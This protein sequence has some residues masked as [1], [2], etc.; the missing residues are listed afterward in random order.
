MSNPSNNGSPPAQMSQLSVAFVD[1]KVSKRAAAKGTLMPQAQDVD[2]RE[3]N[4]SFRSALRTGERIKIYIGDTAVAE[5]TKPLL[6]ATSA[7]LDAMYHNGKITLPA[8]TNKD[9]VD[10]LMGYLA[11]VVN[12]PKR[13]VVMS[14]KLP[15]SEALS[16]CAAAHLLGM[17]KYTDNVY[18]M[19]EAILRSELP[20][21]QDLEDIA[22]F[23]EQHARLFKIVV[24]NLAMRVR[25]GTVP[26]PDDF[27]IY[28]QSNNTLAEAI[29]TANYKHAS[30][31]ARD[32]RRRVQHA[33]DEK[34]KEA[35]KHRAAQWKEKT[36]KRAALENAC[37][38][39]S[40]GG[41]NERKKFTAEERAHWVS[42]RRTQPPK[43][44]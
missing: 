33:N 5:L 39:K 29:K 42:T 41:V 43:G 10:H 9:G 18:K 2:I 28:L 44:C 15:L 20:T 4:S 25:E 35:E 23:A 36:T 22:P 26:D 19:C 32:E 3:W 21:Y 17:G 11:Y 40:R 34:R 6:K 13:P 16:V 31:V 24:Q 1:Q 37:V 38:E 27:N 8:D 14:N 12:T 7:N 30:F